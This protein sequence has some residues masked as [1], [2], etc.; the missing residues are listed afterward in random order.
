MLGSV[1]HLCF[2]MRCRMWDEEVVHQQ[3]K[4][5]AIVRPYKRETASFATTNRGISLLAI[6][7]KI[8]ARVLLNRLIVHMEQGLLSILKSQRGF[9]D[10]R[11]TVDVIFAARQP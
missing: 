2:H 5:A 6:A 11:G 9:R 10:G 3:L 7:G 4:D 1:T 8:L